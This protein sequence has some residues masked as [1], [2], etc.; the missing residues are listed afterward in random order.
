MGSVDTEDLT[1]AAQD[2][3]RRAQDAKA[4]IES[5]EAIRTRAADD[6]AIAV[7]DFVDALGRGGRGQAAAILG[8]NVARLDALLARARKLR[9]SPG[10]PRKS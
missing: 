7:A 2:A 3:L 1:P 5:A 9:D 8:T 6:R 10:A 4:R